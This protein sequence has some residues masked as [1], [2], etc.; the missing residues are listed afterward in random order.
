MNIYEIDAAILDCVDQ[1]TG[2]IVDLDRLKAL[3]I[4]RD[5]K[6]SNVACWIKDLK[7]EAD[8]IKKEVDNLS[9]RKTADENKIKSL[10]QYLDYALNGTKF[11]D[12]RCSISYRRSEAVEVTKEGEAKLPEEFIKIERTVRKSELKDAMKLGFEFEGCTLV[13]KNNIQIR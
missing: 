3:E 2:D 1:E 5:R 12:E 10:K 9:A 6:V 7:A 4:E 13:E 8:A 11:K